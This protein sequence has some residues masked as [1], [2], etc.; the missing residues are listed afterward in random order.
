MVRFHF[1]SGENPG[2]FGAAA[3]MFRRCFTAADRSGAGAER[4]A[5]EAAESRARQLQAA[6]DESVTRARASHDA[7]DEILRRA[8]DFLEEGQDRL[9]SLQ[10]PVRQATNNDP[11]YTTLWHQGELPLG[12]QDHPNLTP[13]AR[14]AAAALR[15]R[16]E[17]QLDLVDGPARNHV[18]EARAHLNEA[19]LTA[20]QGTSVDTSGMRAA[21]AQ[22]DDLIRGTDFTVDR[23]LYLRR[24]LTGEYPGSL[25]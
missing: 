17:E 9:L 3:Q 7:A 8:E 11:Y 21:S 12:W 4:M 1:P 15:Q 19:E 18:I 5:R 16:T 24:S 10:R 23:L 20:L 6:V 25:E 2:V 22:L 13:E 14:R